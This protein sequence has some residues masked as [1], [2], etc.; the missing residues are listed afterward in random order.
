MDGSISRGS[1]AGACGACMPAGGGVITLAVRLVC[2][3][4]VSVA[5]GACGGSDCPSPA[6]APTPSAAGPVPWQRTEERAPCA[7]FDPLRQP[8]FGDLHVHTRVSADATI[9]GTKVGPRDA[10]D[11]ARGATIAVSDENEAPTRTARLERPLDFT[12]VTDHSEWFGEVNLC[13]TPGSPVYDQAICQLLRRADPPDEQSRVTIEWLFPAGIANPPPSLPFC[14][15]PGVD[16]DAAAVSV[17]RELQAAAEEAYDRSAA[18][19]FTSFIGYEHTASPAGRHLH[20]NVIFRNERVPAFAASQLDTAEDGIP[21]GVWKA[22]EDDCLHAGIGCDAVIIPH[23]SNLSSGQQFA[24][25]ADAAEARRRQ[26]R[27]PLVELHQQKGNSECRFDRVAGRGVGTADELCA[28][29]QLLEANQQPR[30]PALPVDQYPARNMVR[31]AL[32]QGLVLEDALGT[33][34]FQFG[35]I[36]STDTHNATSGNVEEGG[37][38]GA[39]GNHDATP[40]LQIGSAMRNNPG[41]LAVVWAE[42]NSRDALFAALRRRE[43]Y[44]T[45][46]TRPIVRFFAGRLDEVRCG[47]P[48][49]VAAGY[50]GGTAMGGE[51]GA[52]RGAASPRFAVLALRD[53]GTPAAPGAALQRVQIIKGWVDAGG[54]SHEAVFDVAGDADNGATVDPATCEPRGG[55]A[56]ELCAVWDDPGFD[57]TQRAFYYAR[58]LEN[59]TCRWSTRVCKAA[60]VDPFAADCTTQAAAAGAD[61]AAC[62]IREADDPFLSPLTQERAWTS[63]IWYRPDGIAALRGAIDFGSGARSDRLSLSI[64]L[65]SVPTGADLEQDGL[66]LEVNDGDALLTVAVPPGAL[67]L[68]AGEP[69]MW[70]G[71]AA[72]GDEMVVTL[73]RPPDGSVVIELEAAALD[74]A[75]AD[76]VSHP[77]EVRLASGV[78]RAS[79]L[80]TW[81]GNAA[82]L[83][84]PDAG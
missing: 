52:V 39:E 58:V 84:A 5:L 42:E 63:P 74:L 61:F 79:A 50:R 57:P 21:Q 82:G 59:P 47:A 17:W 20:R 22:I 71:P 29:E 33:N 18:C 72:S 11:F 69:S 78:Y 12:A 60:G 66:V 28:Y 68:D 35:F 2:G 51:I 65:R 31:N 19:T 34:P 53:P 75:A 4:A 30:A 54:E 26:D 32:K 37:W 7:A 36:G 81:Q 15:L 1:P 49:F 38:V 62:C 8:F 23:N 44:A 25:P 80:R 27:E 16:C 76:R 83:R 6:P 45:S 77:V 14:E 55:G 70:R 56:D 73:A 64:R 67:R 40:A 43:T 48:D 10:Y 24:D 9:Y 3:I 46:G 41:G 13:S